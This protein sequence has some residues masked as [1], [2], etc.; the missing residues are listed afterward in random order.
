MEDQPHLCYR[1]KCVRGRGRSIAI[2]LE[3]EYDLCF[4]KAKLTHKQK[5]ALRRCKS[6]CVPVAYSTAIPTI[7]KCVVR[8]ALS[9][10]YVV[11]AVCLSFLKHLESSWF[12]IANDRLR[13]LRVC[14]QDL[15]NKLGVRP[16]TDNI[17]PSAQLAEH[18]A[19]SVS[20]VK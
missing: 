9:L 2:A 19:A 17:K 11:R 10:H 1:L 7:F 4:S 5:V 6:Y 15:E 20:L 13:K 14:L 16:T 12:G 3:D 18:E 8:H